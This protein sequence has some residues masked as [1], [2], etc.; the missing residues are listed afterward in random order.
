MASQLTEKVESAG[1]EV[2]SGLSVGEKKA[3]HRRVLAEKDN[4]RRRTALNTLKWIT[5]LTP[6]L[7][8][9]D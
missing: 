3:S 5:I 1:T 2:A 9:T 6:P 4:D 7:R 8:L